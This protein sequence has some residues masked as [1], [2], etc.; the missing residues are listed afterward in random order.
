MKHL[1]WVVALG[2]VACS[3]GSDSADGGDDAEQGDAG[4]TRDPYPHACTY[5]RDLDADGKHDWRSSYELDEDGRV[6][7]EEIDNDGDGDLDFV[8]LMTYD[9]EGRQTLRELDEDG[10]GEADYEYETEYRADGQ[11]ARTADSHHG[12]EIASVDFTY[13]DDGFLLERVGNLADGHTHGEAGSRTT[14]E[15]DEDGCAIVITQDDY[16]DGMIELVMTSEVDEDCRPLV[17]ESDQYGDGE[18]DWVWTASYDDDGHVLT[19][20]QVEGEVMTFFRETEWDGELKLRQVETRGTSTY[21][22]EYFYDDAGN[23]ERVMDD[24]FDDGFAVDMTLYDNDARGNVLRV[25]I[26]DHGDGVVDD[27]SVYTYDCWE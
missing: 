3:S 19:E 12:V 25:V 4:V 5:E 11:I 8:N 26:D 23:L 16:D 18:V 22:T 20:K 10:D 17:I 2:L 24:A 14:Y 15:N 13:D 21:V 9:D 27:V 1:A 6:L 7:R